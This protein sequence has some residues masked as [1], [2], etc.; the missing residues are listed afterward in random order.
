M[1]DNQF[2]GKSIRGKSRSEARSSR[3]T[4]MVTGN[5]PEGFTFPERISAR[6]LPPSCPG[7][8]AR[9]MASGFS[10]QEAVSTMPPTF[11]TTMTGLPASRKAFET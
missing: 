11:R 1:K 9:I 4:G 8:H 3:C 7:I 5:F 10:V 6:A 2:T